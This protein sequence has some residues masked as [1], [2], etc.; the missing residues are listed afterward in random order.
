V[1]DEAPLRPGWLRAL[2]LAAL[3]ITLTIYA[4]SSMIAQYPHPSNGDGMMFQ[5]FLEAGRASI[6]RYHEFP[7]WN[8]YECGGCPLWNNPQGFVGAPL[9]WIVLF[10]NS[11]VAIY[12]W[13]IEHVAF[14]FASMWLFARHEVKLSRA[15][16]FVAAAAWAYSGFHQ[17]HYSGGHFAFV[18]WVFFPLALLLWRRAENDVRYAVGLGV[19]TAWMFYEGAVY[20]LP[21]LVLLLG[22]ET[23]T[24][25]WP[26]RRLPGILRAGAIAGVVAFTIAASRLLPVLDQ[27]HQHS[28]P[29]LYDSDAITWPTL[30]AM[31]LARQHGRAVVGQQYVWTEWGTYLGPIVLTLGLLGLVVG[32]AETAWMAVLLALAFVLM[33]GH[34]AK[35]SPW[36]LLTAHVPPFKEMRVPSR[37]RATVSLFL[38]AYAGVA[39]DRLRMAAQRFVPSRPWSRALQTLVFA[40]ALLGVGDVIGVGIDTIPQF[41]TSAPITKPEP[42]AHFYYGG[43]GLAG[44]IDQPAQNRGELSCYDEW[45]FGQ[46]SHLWEGDLPQARAID[47]GATIEG[48]SRTQNTFTVDVMARRPGARVLLNTVFDD[49]WKTNIGKTVNLSNQLAIELP[50][51]GRFHIHAIDRPRTFVVGAILTVIGIAGTVA[52]FVRDTRRRRRD[53][54]TEQPDGR[55]ASGD[56][57]CQPPAVESAE[58]EAA[59]SEGTELC[60][61]VPNKTSQPAKERDDSSLMG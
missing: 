8:A 26:P 61:G 15:A 10:V 39:V 44:F 45:G 40:I 57:S 41:F 60:L 30:K 35:W 49:D 42:A 25:V 6:V 11:T 2:A 17:Q 18:P 48:A 43:P 24:R 23:L 21:H 53:R 20:P 37:F 22:A 29:T 58:A 3:S 4:W 7:F 27:L 50:V 38:A 33:C 14:A 34:F 9:L 52:F 1:S 55:R 32:G 28:R 54:S 19:L 36:S 46:G 5:K 56:P 47:D 51:A 59:E 16:T 31:F 13:V 12:L